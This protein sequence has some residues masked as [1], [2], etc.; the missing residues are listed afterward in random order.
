MLLKKDKFLTATLKRNCYFVQN[1]KKYDIVEKIKKPFFLTI[2]HRKKIKKSILQKIKINFA[3]QLILFKKNYK[4]AK[5]QNCDCRL[6]TKRDIPQLKKIAI[7][8]SSNS[9][10]AKDPKLPKIFRKSIRWLWLKN[11]FNGCRGSYLIVSIINKKIVGFLLILRKKTFWQIDL[12]VVK[13]NCQK[14]SVGS[15]LIN[16]FNN[17]FMK[18]FSKKIICGTQADNYKAINFYKKNNFVPYNKVYIYHLH[19]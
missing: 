5:N 18:S 1:P 6:A 19:G 12:I 15:S 11:F 9:R 3:S 10:F 14:K 8:K 16:Y 17:N 4:F 7:E 13:K 2:K